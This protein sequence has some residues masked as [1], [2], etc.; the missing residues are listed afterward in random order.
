VST[1]TKVVNLKN[2]S[3]DMLVDRTTPFGNP[4]I[5]GPDGD[6]D[7]VISKFRVYW[8]APEQYNL[9]AFARVLLSGKRIGCWCKPQACHGDIIA[10]YL[11]MEEHTTSTKEAK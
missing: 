7:D 6:R 9:R 2:D 11:N 3:Y 5:I 10:E 1:E 8:Y 4:F